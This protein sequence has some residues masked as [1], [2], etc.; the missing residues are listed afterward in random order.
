M[1]EHTSPGLV[2]QLDASEPN[3]PLLTLR[4]SPGHSAELKECLVAKG[5]HVSD[6]IELSAGTWLEVLAV[7]LGARGPLTTAI[8]AFFERNK[9]KQIKFGTNGRLES[10]NGYTAAD[11]ERILREVDAQ[12]QAMQEREAEID[13]ELDL[14][15]DGTP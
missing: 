9:H 15:I 5:L 10:A 2:L 13:R 4:V 1:N 14:G 8:L 11:V 12:Q 7:A 3:S 6:V